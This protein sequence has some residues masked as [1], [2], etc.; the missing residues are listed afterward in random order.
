MERQRIKNLDTFR[1]IAAIIVM[2]A[3]TEGGRWSQFGH[4]YFSYLPSAHISVI[5]FFVISGFLISYLLWEEKKK[6]NTISLQNFY[7]RR[8]LRIWPLY[9]LILILSVCLLQYIPTNKALLYALTITPNIPRAFRLDEWLGSP[10]IWSI[11]V[12]NQFYIIFPLLV[13][14]FS[15]KNFVGILIAFIVVYTLLPHFVDFVNVRTINNSILTDFNYKFYADC[16]FNSL[17]IGCLAG[18]IYSEKNRILYCIYNKL[19][20][21]VC[22]LFTV[23]VW[24]GN[25]NL[26]GY[27]DEILSVMFVVIILNVCTNANL[28]ITFE[29]KMTKFLGRISY[30]IYM[31][32]YIVIAL[33]YKHISFTDSLFSTVMIHVLV[34]TITIFVSWLS[35][36]TYEKFFLNIKKRFER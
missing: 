19:L 2:V 26:Y 33:L 13:L 6:K 24:C 36:E 28:N 32:H 22:T 17:A 23:V 16:K 9:F 8:I 15:K 14:F 34:I 35:F 4:S 20:L 31:Y 11:G 27:T 10:Q 18:F 29:N 1:A 25:I 21:Y 5:L 7:V 12:E 3:H 30:G